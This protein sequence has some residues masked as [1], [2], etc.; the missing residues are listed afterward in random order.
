MFYSKIDDI[1]TANCIGVGVS[2]FVSGCN[3]HCEGCFNQ[4]T[5]D[6]HNGEEFTEKTLSKLISLVQRSYVDCFSVL[7]GEPF[8]ERNKE[9]VLE[10]V[11]TMRGLKKSKLD[12]YIWSG[13]T[14]ENLIKDEVCKEILDNCDYLIDGAFD[15][16]K[17]DMSLKLRGSS[18]QRV[19]DL[20]D[21]RQSNKLVVLN[22]D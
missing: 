2:I 20:R 1:D 10:I 3:R 7:G 4:E 15:M 5:W 18:N 6:F 12:I 19:I 16:S 9:Q 22:L 8:E 21:S 14:Y 13:N 17:K 11:Q